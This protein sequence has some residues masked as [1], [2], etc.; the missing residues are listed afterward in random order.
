M[1]ERLATFDGPE[2]LNTEFD[3]KSY[4]LK[5]RLEGD[6]NSIV[7]HIKKLLP[8]AYTMWTMECFFKLSGKNKL[9]FLWCNDLRVFNTNDPPKIEAF[10][11][12][13]INAMVAGKHKYEKKLLKKDYFKC[14]CAGF[15]IDA[16]C[17]KVGGLHDVTQMKITTYRYMI[18]YHQS[19][20]PVE[21]DVTIPEDAEY[22]KLS[23]YRKRWI[24]EDEMV[25]FKTN[26]DEKS[27]LLKSGSL[28][29]QVPKSTEPFST[30]TGWK[31]IPPLPV[32]N[33]D[34]LIFKVCSKPSTPSP[35][36]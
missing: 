34:P 21:K 14:P 2:Y 15:G 1:N 36:P 28:V 32:T 29:N 27:Y 5:Q 25:K 35:Q 11:A 22:S 18:L 12:P 13:P 17:D 10:L 16:T 31:E 3:I 9:L 8:S 24:E 20:A 23:P 7:S 26:T 33:A 4:K 6:V 30:L 19:Q